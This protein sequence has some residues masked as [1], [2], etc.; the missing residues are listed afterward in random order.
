MWAT[1]SETAVL[2]TAVSGIYIQMLAFYFATTS[3]PFTADY[4][5]TYVLSF[6]G[7]YSLP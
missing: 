3:P 1:I 4:T 6:G 2:R 5:Q 7:P